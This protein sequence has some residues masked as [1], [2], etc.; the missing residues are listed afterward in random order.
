MRDAPIRTWQQGDYLL[1]VFDLCW[2]DRYGKAVVTYRLTHHGEV[3]FPEGADFHCSPL[4]SPDDDGTV[5]AILS[6]CSLKP[7]DTDLRYFADYTPDQLAW[8]RRYGE[9][10][11]F[12]AMELEE[13][14]YATRHHK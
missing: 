8:C 9:D 5:A 12:L 10:L 2:T 1:E 11:A 13:A 3:V 7:G 14:H 6:F 4:N